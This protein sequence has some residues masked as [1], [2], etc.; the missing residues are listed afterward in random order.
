MEKE[1]PDWVP[2]AGL[3]K[4]WGSPSTSELQNTPNPLPPRAPVIAILALLRFS[5]G[6]KPAPSP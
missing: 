1:G 6:S 2:S 4:H 5:A 3:G